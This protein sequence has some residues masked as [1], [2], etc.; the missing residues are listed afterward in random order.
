M[1]KHN[2]TIIGSG[3]LKMGE[4]MTRICRALVDEVRAKRGLPPLTWVGARG[5]ACMRPVPNPP[6]L[7][8]TLH[9]E[10]T[11]QLA[12]KRQQL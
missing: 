2:D 1:T 11:K 8:H 7:Q 10:H 6:G 9:A 12:S 5:M 3:T 4:E